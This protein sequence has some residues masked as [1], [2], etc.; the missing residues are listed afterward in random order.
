MISAI[1]WIRKGVAAQN[2]EKYTLDD[3][4]YKRIHDLAAQHLEEAN[5]DLQDAEITEASAE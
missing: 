5:Q 2:P 4:E 1:Q 3:S